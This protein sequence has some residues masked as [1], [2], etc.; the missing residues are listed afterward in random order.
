MLR[1][2]SIGLPILLLSCDDGAQRV[3]NIEHT[4]PYLDQ[5]EAF[6]NYTHHFDAV[7]VMSANWHGY[8]GV[9]IAVHETEYYYW[10]YSDTPPPLMGPYHGTFEIVD[11]RLILGQPGPGPDS[12]AN[13][14][15]HLY[16]EKWV[17]HRD[18]FGTRLYSETDGIGE[19]A[20]HL[21]LDTQFDPKHPFRN[22]PDLKP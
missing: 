16:A 17:I 14:D 1:V 13:L 7:W 19:V 4:E 12:D 10:M 5:F 8:M 11:D 2:L 3:G 9:A 15:P 21:L 22:Q 6:E 20:R 18:T